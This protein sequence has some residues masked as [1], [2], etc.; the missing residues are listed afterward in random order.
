MTQ[1]PKALLG[2]PFLHPVGYNASDGLHSRSGQMVKFASGQFLQ[3]T[4]DRLVGNRDTQ[5]GTVQPLGP[6]S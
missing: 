6:I 2:N 5:F 1:R 3:P 4:F